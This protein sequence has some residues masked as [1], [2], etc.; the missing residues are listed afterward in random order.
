MKISN[1]GGASLERI[2]ERAVRGLLRSGRLGLRSRCC[3]VFLNKGYFSKDRQKNIVVDVSIELTPPGT[4]KPALVWVWECKD[5]TGA[6]PV[7]DLEEFHAKLEQIG[8]D[9]TKGTV[10]T[11]GRYQHSAIHYAMFKGIGLTRLMSGGIVKVEY[12][13]GFYCAPRGVGGERA[14]SHDE[15]KEGPLSW[16][17]FINPLPQ[18]SEE[19]YFSCLP[20]GEVYSTDVYSSIEM[21]LQRLGKEFCWLKM[22]RV[23]AKLHHFLRGKAANQSAAPDGWR[24]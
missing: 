3:K 20:G 5:Y 13:P 23:E 12:V 6:V 18:F 9:R 1:N 22:S 17:S 19:Y 15:G 10:I 8:A 7:S 11:T 21:E 2:V 24:R 14:L 16:N 4:S